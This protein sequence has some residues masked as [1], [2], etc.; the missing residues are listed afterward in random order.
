M[1]KSRTFEL[2]INS[3]TANP[4][5]LC[6]LG[7][8][9]QMALTIWLYHIFFWEKVK[10]NVFAFYKHDILSLVGVVESKY[11]FHECPV[12]VFVC[13]VHVCLFS[14]WMFCVLHS[15]YVH[16]LLYLRN[17]EWFT[18]II[19]SNMVLKVTTFWSSQNF[20]LKVS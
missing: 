1:I 18:I 8:K 3:C 2:L 15:I 12:I 5:K 19:Q 10:I 7:G 17:L 6:W 16:K 14:F 9:S 13:T 11:I 4:H 20:S